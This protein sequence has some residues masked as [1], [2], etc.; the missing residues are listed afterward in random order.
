M[1]SLLKVK[2]YFD[3]ICPWCLIGKRNLE[4]ALRLLA[5][6]RPDVRVQ[7]AWLG[8]QLLP[9]VPLQGEPAPLRPWGPPRS[10]CPSRAA[11]PSASGNS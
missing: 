7:V 10:C 6:Q 5:Q 9:Q 8:L 2:V 3:F 11:P 1:S 4:T